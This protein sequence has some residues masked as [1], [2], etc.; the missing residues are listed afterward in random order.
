[1]PPPPVTGPGRPI[2]CCERRKSTN[3]PPRQ[4]AHPP[5][6]P[7]MDLGRGARSEDEDRKTLVVSAGLACYTACQG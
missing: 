5:G 7:Q 1:V 6:G 4:A 2:L 3:H